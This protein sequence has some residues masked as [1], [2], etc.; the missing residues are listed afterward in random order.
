MP[1]ISV[2]I[3]LFNK[4]T[5]IKGT[6]ESLLQQTFID[7]EVIILDDGS[8]DDSAQ[9]VNS[10]TDP[11]VHFF[12]KQNEGVASTRN[13]AVA[14]AS[15]QYIA[16]L[17][18]DDLWESNHLE[19]LVDLINTHPDAGLYCAA[20]Q[21]K[22]NDKLT[23]PFSSPLTQK[24]TN[25]QGYID[26]FFE[27]SLSD[28][29]AWTSAVA[30]PK[31]AFEQ[32]GGF[33]TSIT[34]GAGEDTDLWMRA[35]LAYKVAYSNTITATHILDSDNRISH[36]PTLRRNYINLDKYE[37]QSAS[38]RS[39]KKF[40]DVNRYSL[41]IQHK[42]AGDSQSAKK[43]SQKLNPNNLTSKQRILLNLPGSILRYLKKKQQEKISKGTYLTPYKS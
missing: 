22:Y 28:C 6:L 20:Y 30:M 43:Y 1:K 35:A 31:A 21:K 24:P 13:K 14:K 23:L 39:L 12:Q 32:L 25:W 27:A 29:M 5:A 42:M 7:F 16:F 26:N 15:T 36:T 17:D 9:I 3:P 41:A 40:L 38:N 2:I 33:D 37:A 11:R 19:R 10:F 4:E 34:H 18:A 8:T